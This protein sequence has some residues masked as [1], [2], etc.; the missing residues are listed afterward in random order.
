MN[1]HEEIRLLLYDFAAGE[2]LPDRRGV[3][4]SHVAGC[5]DCRADLEG[6]RALLAALPDGTASPA[7]ERPA[8]YWA[9]FPENV[10]KQIRNLEAV[11]TAIPARRNVSAR[12]LFPYRPAFAAAGT[13][14]LLVAAFF[15]ASRLALP[16]ATAPVGD[17]VVSASVP[18]D[19]AVGDYF[20]RSKA[21]LVGLTNLDVSE[22]NSIDLDAERRK[23]GELLDEARRLRRRPL[24]PRS[25]RVIDD[26]ER[27]FLKAKNID[28]GHPADD[29]SMLREGIERNNLL[30][31]V[32][33]S[34]AAYGQASS[35]R[36]AGGEN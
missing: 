36:T 3:V 12:S 14:G 28:R 16:P 2:L 4:E 30:F 17:A 25:A 6:I 26:M 18:P 8:S 23:S 31:R 35:I 24:D 7:D 34:E 19:S 1:D 11:R 32:R 10:E 27:I 33:M 15:A 9:R 20:R 22:G 13:L 29:V 5:A 21:L